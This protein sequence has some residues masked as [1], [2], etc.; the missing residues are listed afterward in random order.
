MNDK[1]QGVVGG[2]MYIC[3]YDIINALN[4]TEQI[5]NVKLFTLTTACYT[6]TER[7]NAFFY[8]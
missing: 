7:A 5:T 1:T 4:S 3:M 2:Q 6:L 8:S